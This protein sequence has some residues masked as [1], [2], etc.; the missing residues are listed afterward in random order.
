[1]TQYDFDI[2]MRYRFYSASFKSKSKIQIDM[3]CSLILGHPET[4]NIVKE[5]DIKLGEWEPNFQL[6]IF[7]VKL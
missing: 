5:M 6:I 7:S 2:D 4:A 1:M 3:R